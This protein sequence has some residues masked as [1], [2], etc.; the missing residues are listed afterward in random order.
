VSGAAGSDEGRDTFINGGKP[1]SA[2]RTNDFGFT[3]MTI[4][5][6]THLDIEQISV[7]EVKLYSLVIYSNETSKILSCM[8]AEGRGIKNA[9]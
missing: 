9:I 3:R 5:N 4:H 6:S 1:W 7:E 2:F 8:N